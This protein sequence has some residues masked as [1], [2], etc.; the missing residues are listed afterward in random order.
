MTLPRVL[1]PMTGRDPHEQHRT[2]TPLDLLFDLTFVIAFAQAASQAA[3]YLEEGHTTTAIAGFAIAVFAVT[4][5]WINLSWL[6]SAYDTDDVAYRVAVFVE[7]VGVLIMALGLPAFFHSLD[8]G[9]HIDNAVMVAGYI[10]MR[11]A[12]IA[13]WLRAARQDRARSRIALTYAPGSGS[14]RSAGSPSSWQIPRYRSRS[15]S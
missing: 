13:L 3:H 11:V 12:T 15:G 2:A 14:R 10:V 7:M 4:W 1:V 5:A 9:E 8:A 6:A